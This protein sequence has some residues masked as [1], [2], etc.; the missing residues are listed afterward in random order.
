[1]HKVE[2]TVDG[3]GHGI[4]KIDGQEMPN[5]LA[6]TLHSDPINGTRVSLDIGYVEVQ[7]DADADVTFTTR[8][9]DH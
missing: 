7:V 2:I 9:E 4:I 6:V 1:M 8:S 3:N 5:V